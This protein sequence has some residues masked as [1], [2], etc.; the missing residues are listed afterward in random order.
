MAAHVDTTFSGVYLPFLAHV[1]GLSRD[2]VTTPPRLRSGAWV[3]FEGRE[4][5]ERWRVWGDAYASHFRRKRR[6]EDLVAAFRAAPGGYLDEDT[7]NDF[8]DVVDDVNT[9]HGA[10]AIESADALNRYAL[11]LHRTRGLD[12]GVDIFP[13]PLRPWVV[14]G[15]AR[16]R[17][18]PPGRRSPRRPSPPQ[19]QPAGDAPLP[20]RRESRRAA[21][22]SSPTPP[23]LLPARTPPGAPVRP[24]QAEQTVAA[25]DRGRAPTSRRRL[26]RASSS[27][28]AGAGDT[29]GA[30]APR[31]RVH[32][33]SAQSV[34]VAFRIND[35]VAFKHA[36]PTPAG[37][38]AALARAA[39]APRWHFGRIT[40]I[41]A[42]Q[43]SL[44]VRCTSDAGAQLEIA[45]VDPRA[46]S[47][48]RVRIAAAPL[49]PPREVHRGDAVAITRRDEDGLAALPG[50]AP[51]S[52]Q[53]A[54]TLLDLQ[55]GERAA[56]DMLAQL[57]ALR[58][59]R[60][61]RGVAPQA[62][63]ATAV[64]NRPRIVAV[65]P[66]RRVEMVYEMQKWVGAEI[67]QVFLRT[68]EGAFDNESDAIERERH[69]GTVVGVYLATTNGSPH[70]AIR[71]ADD[72]EDA[73]FDIASRAALDRRTQDA[74]EP[75]PEAGF[76]SLGAEAHA[77]PRWNWA[78]EVA[79]LWAQ[80]VSGVEVFARVWHNPSF[81]A[82][83][84][85]VTAPRNAVTLDFGEHYA[86]V[87]GATTRTFT[88]RDARRA[89]VR[90][91][92]PD[93]GGGADAWWQDAER[94]D[95]HNQ[96]VAWRHADSPAMTAPGRWLVTAA[97]RTFEEVFETR[98]GAGRGAL[99]ASLWLHR[100]LLLRLA[101]YARP[102]VAD[103]E[104]TP[105]RDVVQRMRAA[106]R[107]AYRVVPREVLE[108]LKL[109]VPTPEEQ[110]A[111]ADADGAAVGGDDNVPDED[112]DALAFVG[113]PGSFIFGWSAMRMGRP[114][115]RYDALDAH[116]VLARFTKATGEDALA[117]E[118][119]S[120]RALNNGEDGKGRI[121]EARAALFRDWRRN[122][123]G[124]DAVF[125]SALMNTAQRGSVQSNI[126]VRAHLQFATHA[127]SS[128]RVRRRIRGADYVQLDKL[129]P[130]VQ[131]FAQA[132]VRD[133]RS[134]YH[135]ERGGGGGVFMRSVCYDYVTGADAAVPY[136][137]FS[138]IVFRHLLDEEGS[139]NLLVSLL[140]SKLD[141]DKQYNVCLVATEFPVFNPFVL[142]NRARPGA[143][144]VSRRC[145][146][147]Q[148][149]MDALFLVYE[150]QDPPVPPEERR[151]F[152]VVL[153]L[154]TIMEMGRSGG[155]A[156]LETPP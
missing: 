45:G 72:R 151:G 102:A 24:S 53:H 147:Q 43:G 91:I 118:S 88:E 124:L 110:A 23:R 49:P 26:S 39:A 58:A 40:A 154:K 57:P 105:L 101:A 120:Q 71:W 104:S 5:R 93:E 79:Q 86:E 96:I 35:V 18:A 117:V 77:P 16:G 125:H 66:W 73:A 129:Q 113:F 9:R 128:G 92:A 133:P 127:L 20:P 29:G 107:H 28:A 25:R 137:N 80:R 37:L 48:S 56:Q 138:E 116:A 155:Y 140:S 42:E 74:V 119:S 81:Y 144:T 153:E 8:I 36:E 38:T 68:V 150:Q 12:R 90:I 134:A 112:E 143:R 100:A 11:L 17:S 15:R 115:F 50:G 33:R 145:L 44:T 114:A 94:R 46:S 95:V 136:A 59:P 83:V 108:T 149:Q 27:E 54:A 123:D 131:F 21:A 84:V 2:L 76:V 55:D 41:D 89:K 152:L 97:G 98:Y 60:P 67:T 63:V 122:A 51:L 85:N 32:A 121:T 99:Y 111:A 82:R 70:F 65:P 103:D 142:V 69:W 22:S 7:Q 4:G 30:A 106:T 126:G 19:L 52:A 3:P 31:R 61:R 1:A 148:T 141:E 87:H 64:A 34:E 139:D 47:A 135:T 130:S 146:M 75:A 78:R 6:L 13:P 10:E 14:A 62:P 156:P 132:S 109:V